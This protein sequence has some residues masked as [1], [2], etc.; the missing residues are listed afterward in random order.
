[1]TTDVSAWRR[2]AIETFPELDA[3][4]RN[5][6]ETFS[7]YALWFELLPLVR[8]AHRDSDDDLLRRIYGFAEWCSEQ[9]GELSNAV[10]V[11]FYEH[12][13][14]ERWMRPLVV[15]FL[16]DRIVRDVTPLWESRLSP[17]DMR[18]IEKLL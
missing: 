11:S 7:V 8:Q 18:A 9:Q 15:P 2:R 12:L 3:E 1:V 14:D 16:T 6:S 17:T 13:F 4:L 5:S 10:A